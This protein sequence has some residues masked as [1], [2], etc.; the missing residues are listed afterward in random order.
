MKTILLMVALYT[1]IVA[2][3]GTLFTPAQ[4]DPCMCIGFPTFMCCSGQ[5]VYT[6][7][8]WVVVAILIVLVAAA[9]IGQTIYDK[10]KDE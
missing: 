7:N 6:P 1:G 5:S 4:V 8:A 10:T 2:L 3:V 9:V